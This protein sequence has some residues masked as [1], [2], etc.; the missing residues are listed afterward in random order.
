MRLSVV[1][2]LIAHARGHD[3]GAAVFKLGVKLA[4][5]AQQNVALAAPVIGQI[6]AL[7]C[8]MRTRTEAN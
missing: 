8:T 6:P 4:L 5:K 7:Y 1:G 3:K 2:Y